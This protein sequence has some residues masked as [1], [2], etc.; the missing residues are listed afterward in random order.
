MKKSPDQLREEILRLTQE[1]S[2][3]VHRSLS[4]EPRD[5]VP[6]ETVIPYAGRVFDA[7]EVVAAVG[8]SL[9]FWLTLGAEDQPQAS[10]RKAPASRR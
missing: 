8:S 3:A 1:Y 9:D 5:F 6:G 7:D 2:G 10:R 4:P